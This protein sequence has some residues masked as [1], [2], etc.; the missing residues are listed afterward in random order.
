[1]DYVRVTALI[2]KFFPEFDADKIIQK[3]KE[4]RNWATSEY[5]G[6]STEEI[7]NK[8]ETNRN[9]A[10]DAG[11]EMHAKIEQHMNYLMKKQELFPPNE[12][13][14]PKRWRDNSLECKSFRRFIKKRLKKWNVYSSEFPLMNDDYRIRGTADALFIDPKDGCLILADWKHSKEIKLENRYEKGLEFLAHLDNCNYYHYCLQLNIYKFL[15]EKK[16]G[17]RV[18]KL[19]LVNI[20]PTGGLQEW[21]IPDMKTEAFELIKR[22]KNFSTTTSIS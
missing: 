8:W 3:M 2:H 9:T 15:I 10:A 22:A 17:L 1:M 19:L 20:P 12:S 5:F 6:L 21:T 13:I 16:T 18:K 4:S 14:V 7:K 11:T